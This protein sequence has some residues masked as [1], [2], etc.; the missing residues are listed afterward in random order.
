MEAF[1]AFASSRQ[2]GLLRSAFLLCGDKAEAEDL[3]QTTLLNLYRS[4]AKAS[5]A[6]SLDAYTRR[7]MVNAYLRNARRRRH[8]HEGH[9]VPV[10][11][12]ASG[13]DDDRVLMRQVL[14][15]ALGRLGPRG[16][17]VVIL[18]YWD[19]LSVEETAAVL[20]CSPGT[21]KSQASRALAR[22]RA[23]LGDSFPEFQTGWKISDVAGRSHD[24]R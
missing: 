6:D 14:L 8:E 15:A 3:V 22:L 21:V 24:E 2:R 4:W 17:A 19:D 9:D 20:R 11:R 12:Q 23:T 7:V 13:P 16:R 18:R 10:P 1:V 5:R